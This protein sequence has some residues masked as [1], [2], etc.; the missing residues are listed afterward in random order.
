MTLSTG[1]AGPPWLLWISRKKQETAYILFGLAGVAIVACMWLLWL[2][3]DLW[4]PEIISLA[5]VAI[6]GFVGGIWYMN[7]GQDGLTDE[8]AARMLVLSVGSL[9]GLCID[10]VAIFRT[11]LW[12]SIITSMDKWQGPGSWRMVYWGCAALL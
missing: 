12:W 5:A 2:H 10:F 8:Q 1:S 9:L 11:V 3:R 6:V 4:W 7:R